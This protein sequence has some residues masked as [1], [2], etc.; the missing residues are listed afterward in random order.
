MTCDAEV[1]AAIDRV[2]TEFGGLDV[3]HANAG[4]A[5]AGG[6]LDQTEEYWDFIFDLNVKSVWLCSSTPSRT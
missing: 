6:S 2:A 4:T 1:A 5:R 3:L